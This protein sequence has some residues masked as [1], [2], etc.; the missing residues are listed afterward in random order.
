ML[1]TTVT[2]SRGCIENDREDDCGC[3]CGHGNTVADEGRIDFEEVTNE[4]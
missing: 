4:L 1:T 2:A 3:H